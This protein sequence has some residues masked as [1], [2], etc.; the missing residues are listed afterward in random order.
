MTRANLPPSLVGLLFLST[1]CPNFAFGQPSSSPRP[2]EVWVRGSDIYTPEHALTL[3]L[4]DALEE[5]IGVKVGI[6]T[7]SDQTI[8]WLPDDVRLEG[9]KFTYRALLADKQFHVLHSGAGE[10]DMRKL[11]DCARAILHDLDR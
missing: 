6:T 10:C 9:D 7:A 5:V 2:T 8:V 3:H 11:E 4:R 1:M